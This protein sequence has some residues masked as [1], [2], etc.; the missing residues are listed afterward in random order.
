MPYRYLV[1]IA[2]DKSHDASTEVT[3]LEMSNCIRSTTGWLDGL[4]CI[5]SKSR[6][7]LFYKEDD[8]EG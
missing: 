3:K 4:V 7:C 5:Q 8:G 1:Q 6:L 2:D